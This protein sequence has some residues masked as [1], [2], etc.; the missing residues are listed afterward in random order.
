MISV[1]YCISGEM[2]ALDVW[3]TH[4]SNIVSPY[5]ADVF[6][7]TWKRGIAGLSDDPFKERGGWSPHVYSNFE[8]LATISPT[9]FLIEDKSNLV[10]D[11][12]QEVKRQ[13]KWADVVPRERCFYMW[14]GWYYSNMISTFRKPYDVIIRGRTDI[15]YGSQ[16]EVDIEALEDRTVYIP[17]GNDNAG[18]CDWFAMGKADTM[19]V[20]SSLYVKVVDYLREGIALHPEYMLAHHLKTHNISVKRFPHRWTLHRTFI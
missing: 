2:R 5:N 7:H 9:S 8:A 19:S 6:L 13:P 1:G 11:Y 4:T 16:I 3:H 18:Y 12:C 17:E 10:V 14:R 15:L 20:Y